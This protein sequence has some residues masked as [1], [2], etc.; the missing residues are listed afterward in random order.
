M[1]DLL[2]N[3]EVTPKAQSPTSWESAGSGGP[4]CS[5]GS[6]DPKVKHLGGEEV[7]RSGAGWAEL[8][9]AGLNAQGGWEVGG[10][11]LVPTEQVGLGGQHCPPGWARLLRSRQVRLAP[12][13]LPCVC[14]EGS[15]GA[16]DS[17][18]LSYF[19]TQISRLGSQVCVGVSSRGQLMLSSAIVFIMSMFRLFAMG[20]IS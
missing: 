17:S 6:R 10:V 13:S 3:L 7:S 12:F 18:F 15:L 16:L 11:F 9:G 20:F 8:P 1:T 14:D 5:Q 4:E 19:P 2:V